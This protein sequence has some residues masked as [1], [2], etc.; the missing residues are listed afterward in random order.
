MD[1][2]LWGCWC[3]LFVLIPSLPGDLL[4]VR[5]KLGQQP[6]GKLNRVCKKFVKNLVGTLVKPARVST[7]SEPGL[8]HSKHV[9]TF[10]NLF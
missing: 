8:R 1:S 7:V 9:I 2:L 6:Q 3:G 10:L 4:L 5:T